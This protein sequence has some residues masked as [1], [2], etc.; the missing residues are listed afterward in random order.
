MGSAL[1]G[2]DRGAG[3]RQPGHFAQANGGTLLIQGVEELGLDLQAALLKAVQDG[4]IQPLGGKRPQRVDVR[5]IA[6]AHAS[7]IERVRRGL[8]REDLYYRLHVL[9][10]TLPSLRT[11]RE[12]IP[13]LAEAFLARFAA[14]EGKPVT[15]LAP[16]IPP[17]LCAY[18][19]PGNVRQLENAVY[20]AVALAEGPLLTPAEFPQIAAQVS[21]SPIVIPPLPP[22]SSPVREVVRIEVR[23]PHTLSLLDEAGEIRRLDDL[24]GEIIR[25]ALEHYRGH[26]SAVSRHLGIGRS[27]LYRKLKDLGL[28]NVS[29]DAAA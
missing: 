15:G 2:L 29:A 3:G 1:F 18:D 13:A 10:I 25:F 22:A 4:E 6:T 19:W 17:L 8:F 14:E 27:T 26:M 11:R 23:D 9:P 28:E 5:V 12:A 24:E 20:R 21:G 16:D 7:L